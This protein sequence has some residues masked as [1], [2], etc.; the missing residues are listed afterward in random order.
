MARFFELALVSLM[1]ACGSADFVAPPE[2][3]S[4]DPEALHDWLSAGSYEPWQ[5]ESAVL[6]GLNGAGRRVFL[7]EAIDPAG[8]PVGAAGVRELYDGVDGPQIGWSVLIKVDDSEDALQ[9]WYFYETFN[10]EVRTEHAI[11]GRGAPGCGF[12]HGSA[13]DVIQSSLPLP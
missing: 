2:P 3:P 1:V 4:D 8:S 9:N 10:L 12:C 13:P 7:N 11:A 6:P 5:A